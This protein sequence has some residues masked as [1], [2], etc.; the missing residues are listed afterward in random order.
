MG[1]LNGNGEII[2]NKP[3]NGLA[4]KNLNSLLNENVYDFCGGFDSKVE[5]RQ[6]LGLFFLSRSDAEVYLKAVA[7]A[8]IDGTQTVGLSINCIGLDAA[9]KVTREHHP[10]VDFR[11]VPDLAEVQNFLSTYV[12][13]QDVVIEEEQQ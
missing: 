3:S 1:D 4:Q 8:D 11:F 12:N 2:L 6:Q 5:K 10:G 9:Y 13:K 7:Q